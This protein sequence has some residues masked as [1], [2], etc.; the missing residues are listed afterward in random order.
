MSHYDWKGLVIGSIISALIFLIVY[1][2]WFNP[3]FFTNSYERVKSSTGTNLK[4]SIEQ[5]LSVISCLN[6]LNRKIEVQKEKSPIAVNIFIKEYQ[7]FNNNQDALNYLS[8]WEFGTTSFKTNYFIPIDLGDWFSKE[9]NDII[10]I[11]VKEEFS[12]AGTSLSQLYPYLC[13]DGKLITEKRCPQGVMTGIQLKKNL[14]SYGASINPTDYPT[15]S[16][17]VYSNNT[18]LQNYSLI[19]KDDKGKVIELSSG[20]NT[21]GG[22]VEV[23]TPDLKSGSR[24]DITFS[25]TTSCGT[26]EE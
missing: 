10:I 6:S 4:S 26:Y 20:N 9:Q 7:K 14:P 2:I 12:N 11:L 3:T 25:F 24:I 5:D 13:I 22:K 19:L 8:S 17:E 15:L 21:A 1:S 16:Y 23:K 18:D